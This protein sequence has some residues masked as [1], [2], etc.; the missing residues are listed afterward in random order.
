MTIK[1]REWIFLSSAKHKTLSQC[2][3]HLKVTWKGNNLYQVF[4]YILLAFC[5]LSSYADECTKFHVVTEN[6]AST[7][8]CID[9]NQADKVVSS[10]TYKI[11]LDSRFEKQFIDADNVDYPPTSV[12][13]FYYNK[14][15]IASSTSTPKKTFSALFSSTGWIAPTAIYN[16]EHPPKKMLLNGNKFKVSGSEPLRIF[17]QYDS[18]NYAASYHYRLEEGAVDNDKFMFHHHTQTITSKPSNNIGTYTIR[19][20]AYNSIHSITRDFKIDIVDNLTPSPRLD[21]IVYGK[22]DK[23]LLERITIEDAD[24]Y[25]YSIHNNP[26]WLVINPYTRSLSG[27]TNNAGVYNNISIIATNDHNTIEFPPITIIISEDVKIAPIKTFEYPAAEVFAG[28]QLSL[29]GRKSNRYDSPV[30]PVS[31]SMHRIWSGNDKADWIKVN[32]YGDISGIPTSNRTELVSAALHITSANGQYTTIAPLHVTIKKST[33]PTISGSPST[34]V[35]EHQQYTFT[36]QAS[37]NETPENLSYSIEN[38][39]HWAD[40]D[41]ATGTISGIPQDSD[42]GQYNNITIRVSDGL[43]TDALSSFSINVIGKNDPPIAR[44]QHI[45]LNED[46]MTLF[47]LNAEDIDSTHLTYKII[48]SP[49]NGEITLNGS[50]GTYTANRNYHGSDSFTFRATD[51]EGLFSDAIVNITIRPI[52]DRPSISISSTRV[53]ILEDQFFRFT[54][55]ITDV[56][57][58]ALSIHISNKPSWMSF[59]TMT[60]ELSGTPKQN[61]IGQYYNLIYY[62]SDGQTSAN[63]SF[64]NVTVLNENDAPNLSGVA[65]RSIDE[66]TQY[67]FKPTLID[68]DHGDSHSF[69]I[70][71]KPSWASFNNTSGE[72]TGTPNNDD[73]GIYQNIKISVVDF[74]GLSDSLTPFSITVNNVNNAPELTGAANSEATEEKLYS[75]NPTLRDI[76]KDDSHSFSIVNKP[77]WVS[78]NQSTGELRGYPDDNDIGEYNNILLS[79]TDKEGLKASLPAFRITVI[80]VND[81]PTLTG[82][83]LAEIDQDEQYVFTPEVIDPDK[84]EKHSFTIENKPSWANFNSNN[85]T[86]SGKPDNSHVGEYS[87]IEISV[88]DKSLA[89]SLLPSFS[90]TVN[91]INDAPTITGEPNKLIP[92]D[93]AYSFTPVINDIDVD[94]TYTVSIQNKPDWAVFSNETGNLSGTPTN[95]YVG[96]TESITLTV[97]DKAGEK[98]ALTPFII[99]VEN[100]NDKPQLTGTPQSNVAQDS[101]YTFT[102]ILSDI[103]VDDSHTFAIQNK[104]EWASFNSVSGTLSGTPLNEHVGFTEN[105]I[106]SVTD[107]AVEKATLPAFVIQVTNVNDAPVLTG[108]PATSI[109]ED[110]LYSFT[111]SLTDVD[112]DDSHTFSIENSPVW[113]TFNTTSGVLSGTPTNKHIGSTDNIL[114]S[115][116]DKAGEKATLPAFNITVKNVNDAPQLTGTPSSSVAQGSLYTFTP[117]LTDIDINDSHTFAIQNR[118]EWARFNSESGTVSGT[119]LNKHV[120]FTENIIISVTDKAGEKAT[121]PA[122]DITVENVNDAPQLTGT[123]SSNVA[124]DSVYTFTP[125]LIDVD[126]S[127]S[128]TFAILNKPEWASFNSESGTLTGTPLNKH[129]GSTDNVII[130]VTDKA[131]EKATLLTFSIT[132]SNINDAPQLTG[133]P[134]ATVAQDSPYTFTPTLSDIDVDDSHTFAI[135][136]RPEWATFNTESGTLSGTPLNEHVDYNTNIII[137][138]TD[139]AGATATLPTFSIEVINANDA[140]TLTGTPRTEVTEGNVYHFI[141]TLTDPDVGDDHTFSIINK[142]E[143]A[144]FDT[145]NGALTGTPLDQHVGLTENIII[146]VKDNVADSLSVS[147]APFSITVINSPDIP[148]AEPFQFTLNEG[149]ALSIGKVNGLLSTATD[150]DLDSGDTLIA[151]LRDTVKYGTLTLNESGAFTYEHDGS[152]TLE[153]TFTYRVKDSTDLVSTTQTVTLTINP[154]DDA[155]IAKND[156]ASTQEDTPVTFSLIDNDTDAEQ[157]LVAASAVLVTEPKF[158]SVSITNGI[159]TYT[160]NE[161]ANGP[162]SFTYTVS[163]STPLTSEPATVNIA[164][165]AV[166]DAPKATNIA[167]TTDEDTNLVILVDDIRSQ[168]SDIE[169]TNPTGGIKLTSEPTHGVVTLSQ[170]DGT[171]TYIPNLNVVATDTFKY[172]IADSNEEVSNEATISINIGAINDRPVVENDSVQT[173]EDTPLTLDILHNDSDVEDQGF[174]GANITLEDQGKGEGLFDL[175]TVTVNA[176]GQLH[177]APAK[178]AVGELTF[179]Y[180]L[181]DSE[182]LASVPAT[183]KVTIKPVND[184]PVAENNT[185]TVQ[186]DG[187]FEINILGND[188]DVDANDKLDVASVTLTDAASSGTVVISATGTATYTPNENFSG[189]D[190]FTYTIKDIAGAISNKAEVLV[191]V[192]AVNDAPV[193][194]PSA[195][196]VAEDGRIDITL[197]GT[198]IEKS[199]LT[200]KISTPPSNGVLTPVS[201]AVW[202]YTPTANFNGTDSIAFIAN[203]GELDSAPAQIA[204]TITAINDA[205]NAQNVSATTDEE[206]PIS[207]TLNGSDIDGDNLSFIIINQPSNGTATLSGGQVNYT[208]NDDFTGTDSFSYQA[209]DGSLTSQT[210]VA[211]IQVNNVNDAPSIAGTPATTVRQGNTYTFTPSVTDIDSTQ[212][213]YTIAN[214]PTWANFDRTT[215]TLSGTPARGDVG[216]SNNIV[217]TV[218]DQELTASLPAF[219]IEVSFTNTPPRAQAQTI[220]VQEDGTTS[221]IPTINDI[222]GDTLSI[223]IVTQP[224]AGIASVQG[225]TLTYTPNTNYNGEDTLTYIVDDGTDKSSEARIAI[226]VVSVNDMPQAN[227]DTFTFD[228]NDANRY[229]LDVLSND[230]DL[231][232]QPLTIVGAQTSIGS[233]VVE[234]NQ[235]VYQA[236]T[237]ASTTVTIHYVI[238]DPEQARSASSATLNITSQQTGLPVITAPAD[239]SVNATG[240]FTK[241]ELGV[242]TATDSQGNTLAVSL[243]TNKRIFTPGKHL[244]YWQTQDSQARMAMASHTVMVNP[245]V[246]IDQGFTVSEGSSNTI[247]VQ[248]NGD[249]PSYPVTIPY[250]VSGSASAADHTLENGEIVI[251]SGRSGIITFDVIQDDLQ[252]KGEAIIITLGNEVNANSSS[253]TA[254]I[255]IE[256]GNIAP[257]ITTKIS[258]QGENRTLVAAD[259][260]E[261]SLLATV[262]DANADDVLQ[263]SWASTDPRLHNTS[264]TDKEFTFSP[265][266]LPA[267]N[268][269]ITAS[270][271]DNATPALTTS[272]DV[273]FEIIAQL[274]A[275]TSQDSDGD[276]IPDNEE[277]YADSDGDGIPDYLDAI[278]QPNVL[279]GSAGNST[280]H[281]IEAQPGTSLRKGTSVAQNSSGGAQ[282]LSSELPSDDTAQNVGGLYDFIA[283]GL[284]NAGDVFT[285]VLPQYEQVPLNA[286]YRKYKNGEWVNF[287]LGDGNTVMSAQGESGYCPAASSSQ[288]HEG[289]NPGHWCIK[290]QIV[291]GGPNDDD[292]L[293]NK[294]V[295]DPSGMAIVLNGNSLPVTTEDT[296]TITAGKRTQLDVLSNDNDADG[297]VLSIVNV[298]SDI[299]TVELNGNDIYFTPPNNFAGLAQL[300]YMI[301]D[302]QGGSATGHASITIV[303]NS[304]PIATRDTAS[305]KDNQT[306]EIDVLANDHDVD[307]DTLTVTAASVDEGSVR[308]TSG[309]TLSFVPTKGFAGNATI[310][311]TISDNA[312]ATANGDVIV[313]VTLSPTETP[314][315]PT[316][317]A[318]PEKAKKSSGSFNLLL[319]I[320]LSLIMRRNKHLF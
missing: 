179:T 18:P 20:T 70:L 233:V 301:G 41:P 86:L 206:T 45:Y 180:V 267:G 87:N 44:E 116:T 204:I 205:P 294:S 91:N 280:A 111:P 113:A 31:Y 190:S 164:V 229:V 98:A 5:S 135:Q 157:K 160:P 176:D 284:M 125:T 225:N 317:D 304:A 33:A 121:L 53:S 159:A 186:E 257:Q 38:M 292:G 193:A 93:Q 277:G 155:P 7:L 25:T 182:A 297:D 10:V 23:F 79:V 118:P 178:D 71:N 308:I 256:E 149:E 26:D 11:Q 230:T 76:D 194:T 171:L 253:N 283:S 101:P 115:V 131:G 78:L 274:A 107:K 56:D 72:L 117:T 234:N 141:P 262:S 302:T 235:L 263:I 314:T 200:Y 261:V 305:T 231:D 213:S 242:A 222:D 130:S 62:V 175:A 54:P 289:L 208:P 223:E 246:S 300:T 245:I 32:Q 152:E 310:L 239:I 173:D 120:G 270:V 119:P 264:G 110:V 144:D 143:W 8:Q 124:Q 198:D 181:T 158:G 216:T 281:L 96:N 74:A 28:Q 240:L 249:A 271:T 14:F 21:P 52:N 82:S 218:S 81:E 139:K 196:T 60:G 128:H 3:N 295:V 47:M 112:L 272:Q 85:G 221:F 57:D 188:T 318:Q 248:L 63:S 247:S 75:F 88:L 147:L 122:F 244:V 226:N 313:T 279:Q 55:T 252:E 58:D 278:S 207:I 214:K 42:V 319:L 1:R 102:P 211:D 260:G 84:D 64:F 232:E 241:V 303:M 293:A 250:T 39:P 210:A 13:Y 197:T 191:T 238:V 167:K 316:P 195:M 259:Q 268:Y 220:S 192:E 140:A 61:N 66:D 187:S 217:I 219:A 133:T 309:N 288:W 29:S 174:N 90:I 243:V 46:Q 266:K 172:T 103:D 99:T 282:L 163:D 312:G 49:Q 306:L 209:N 40:F 17:L 100:T 169:D 269:T 68:E 89:R 320:L 275:L 24:S 291:D 92:Q 132:V 287:T 311:Y 146:S 4:A 236:P 43:L 290:L 166:N 16:N 151:I 148:S 136:N 183:V 150:V 137:S 298:T 77:K 19:L 97:T 2:N 37:D 35:N 315:K 285:I 142:P 199:A 36:P 145:S 227:P 27:K 228:G 168:A 138:V 203:D 114:I 80:N 254:T 156:E 12:G 299:G 255:S 94:D 106:I 258:Q 105:I 134:S 34:A 307:G 73:V 127:D 59:N 273:Y 48:K 15:T 153:D 161:H 65:L 6:N 162:D 184:A 224:N 123:P 69:S 108:T 189:S 50:E 286:I 22:V 83:P 296:F 265:A 51:N 104:P 237:Q 154:V 177:I 165:A 201:G 185:A 251:A 95:E 30:G 202:S 126:K 276:M 67:S 109:N 9:E 215:G 129:V 170:A 212:F